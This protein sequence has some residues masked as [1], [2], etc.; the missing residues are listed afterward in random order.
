MT[1]P[2]LASRT[3]CGISIEESTRVHSRTCRVVERGP[4]VEVVSCQGSKGGAFNT[5]AR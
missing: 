2:E 1:H 5:E 3:A 4:M